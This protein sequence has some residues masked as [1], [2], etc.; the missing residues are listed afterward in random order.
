MGSVFGK[1]DVECAR[2]TVN[3]RLPDGIEIRHYAPCVA[4]ET[5]CQSLV[6]SDG[7]NNAFRRLA[8]YIGVFGTPENEAA[9]TVAMTAPVMN[10]K[11]QTVAMTAPVMNSNGMMQFLLP[12]KYQTVAEAPKPTNKDVHLRQMDARWLAALTF[13][14]T[15]SDAVAEKRAAQLHAALVVAGILEQDS[16]MGTFEVARFNPPWTIPPF[17][18]NEVLM[19]VPPQQ[20]TPNSG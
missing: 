1:I 3:R 20:S 6:S 14:G 13:S 4:V 7:N 19:A 10:T 8:K 5:A 9:Q 2:F 15:A 11:P 12:A 17:K 18:T 16:E